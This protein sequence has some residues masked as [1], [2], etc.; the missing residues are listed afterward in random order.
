MA[1]ESMH[2]PADALRIVKERAADMFNI[3][4]MKSSGIHEARKIA[5]IAD[6][7]SMLCQV[8]CMAESNVGITGALHFVLA[9][10]IVQFADWI[11]TYFSL[12]KR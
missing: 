6:A 10:R 7:A 1:D 8:G 4:L 2:T 11:V 12:R 5:A 9:N 3:K